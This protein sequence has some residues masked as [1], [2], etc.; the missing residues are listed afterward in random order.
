MPNLYVTPSNE[1]QFSVTGSHPDG[2]T[3]TL[4]SADVTEIDS[5]VQGSNPAWFVYTTSTTQVTDGNFTLSVNFDWDATLVPHPAIIKIKLICTD[6]IGDTP[7]EIETIFDVDTRDIA[8]TPVPTDITGLRSWFD[9]SSLVGYSNLDVCASW[10]NLAPGGTDFL[11]QYETDKKPTYIASDPDCNGYPALQF[12]NYND[13]MYWSGTTGDFYTIFFVIKL[14]STFNT[15]PRRILLDNLGSLSLIWMQYSADGKDISIHNTAE[16]SQGGFNGFEGYNIYSLVFRHATDEVDP[17]KSSVLYV[18]GVMHL[19]GIWNTNNL[20]TASLFDKMGGRVTETLVYDG[21]LSHVDRTSVER[22]LSRKYDLWVGSNDNFAP[23]GISSCVG[24][25]VADDIAGGDI[26]GSDGVITWADQSGSGNDLTQATAGSRPIV[27]EDAAAGK[28]TLLFDGVDDYL[29]SGTFGTAIPATSSIFVVVKANQ[30]EGD[31]TIIDGI[32]ATN[33]QTIET[34]TG[35][36]ISIDQGLGTPAV[37]AADLG[38]YTVVAGIFGPTDYVYA[39]RDEKAAG[40]Q[41]T[42][43]LTG[44]TVGAQWDGSAKY[45]KGEI[46]EIIIFDESLNHGRRT[47]IE[48]YLAWKYGTDFYAFS[49]NP[50]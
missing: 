27:L 2:R 47:Q 17:L 1:I 50:I 15:N 6:G 32:S 16:S 39:N 9:V 41:G 18:N 42:Q 14:T 19:N 33:R 10:E 24:W 34:G 45:L 13:Y 36:K 11:V 22:Y 35:Q 5:V 28:R 30:Q 26:D 25:Y 46:A 12:D 48:C 29:Q 8:Y 37:G 31:Q 23:S 7:E 49:P 20:T 40:N 44:L 4:V 3:L 43:T 38:D 21:D